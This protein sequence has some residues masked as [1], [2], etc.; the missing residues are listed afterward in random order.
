ML[1]VEDATQL[2]ISQAMRVCSR[3]RH[4]SG[5]LDFDIGTATNNIVREFNDPIARSLVRRKKNLDSQKPPP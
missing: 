2:G 4:H 5:R 3:L 1:G